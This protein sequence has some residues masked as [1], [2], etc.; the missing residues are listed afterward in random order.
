MPKT[1]IHQF[2]VRV[3]VK[4]GRSCELRVF[5]PDPVTATAFAL[6]SQ[7]AKVELLGQEPLAVRVTQLNSNVPIEFPE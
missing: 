5:A 1:R 4:S 2:I 6:N 7:E 3:S